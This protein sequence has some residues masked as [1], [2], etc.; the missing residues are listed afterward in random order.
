MIDIILKYYGKE[1]NIYK[2]IE[3]THKK[4]IKQN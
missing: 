1:I 2:S 3:T 4:A